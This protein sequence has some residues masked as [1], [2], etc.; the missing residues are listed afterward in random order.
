MRD[1]VNKV[2]LYSPRASFLCREHD[3][4]NGFEFVQNDGLHAAIL[5]VVVDKVVGKE[6]VG[7]IIRE[8]VSDTIFSEALEGFDTA[9]N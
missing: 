5:D 8:S 6:P 7:H 3:V 9:L 4:C 1:A 2:G